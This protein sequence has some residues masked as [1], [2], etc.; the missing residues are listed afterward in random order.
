MSFIPDR[1]E[2]EE[3]E[4]E[5]TG[6]DG[7]PDA[8]ADAPD[9]QGEGMSDAV[10]TNEESETRNSADENGEDISRTDGSEET[11]SEDTTAD[12]VT[13]GNFGVLPSRDEQSTSGSDDNSSSNSSS[14]DSDDTD[15]SPTTPTD[16]RADSVADGNF[17][18]LDD[19]SDLDSSPDSSSSG[20]SE[21]TAPETGPGGIPQGDVVNTPTAERSS[22]DESSQQS[23]QKSNQPR[24]STRENNDTDSGSQDSVPD[25]GI[26]TA[27]E[28]ENPTEADIPFSDEVSDPA[29]NDDVNYVRTGDGRIVSDDRYAELEEA[30][31]RLNRP[32]APETGPSGIPQ[33]NEVGTPTADDERTEYGPED[34][35]FTTKEELEK[36]GADVSA[37]EGG[38]DTRVVT[39]STYFEEKELAKRVE[40]ETGFDTN[41]Q[42]VIQSDDGPVLSPGAEDEFELYKEDQ[43]E[44]QLAGNLDDDYPGVDVSG[45]DVVGFEQTNDGVRPELDFETQRQLVAA[46]AGVDPSEVQ[47]T[48]DGFELT[49]PSR[50]EQSNRE[51]KLDFVQWKLNKGEDVEGVETTTETEEI[52]VPIT[53][54]T[55][56]REEQEA[57]VNLDQVSVPD[58][59]QQSWMDEGE[60]NLSLDSEDVGEDLSTTEPAVQG[61]ETV[62]PTESQYQAINPGAGGLQVDIDPGRLEALDAFTT[63]GLIAENDYSRDD[64]PLP[65]LVTDATGVTEK[66]ITQASQAFSENVAEPAG[67]YLGG[68]VDTVT[69]PVT[70]EKGET[71]AGS[72]VESGTQTAIN[73]ANAPAWVNSAETIVEVGEEATVQGTKTIDPTDQADFDSTEVVGAGAEVT[74]SARQQLTKQIKEDPAGLAGSVTAGVA[75][76]YLSG[77]AASR[78][79][80][81]LRGRLATKNIDAQGEIDI[82]EIERPDVRSGESRLTRFSEQAV[83]GGKNS[84]DPDDFPVQAANDPE[85]ELR[86]L[87]EEYA[88]KD[89]EDALDTGPDEVTLFSARSGMKGDSFEPR[90]GRPYDPDAAFFAGSVSRNFLDVTGV[91]SASGLSRPRLPR[92]IKGAKSLFQA[93][94]N[95]PTIVATAGELDTLPD[96]VRTRGE[97]TEFLQENR[98]TD[99]FFVR[100][101]GNQS[102][103]AEAIVSARGADKKDPWQG[104]GQVESGETTE[105]VEY[106]DPFITEVEGERVPI[107]LF[108]QRSDGDSGTSG[109]EIDIADVDAETVTE[110]E[111]VDIATSEY[112][113]GNDGEPVSPPSGGPVATEDTSVTESGT[114][115]KAP[116]IGETI[117]SSPNQDVD[118]TAV[119]PVDETILSDPSGGVQDS[120]APFIGDEM[121]TEP[122]E[123]PSSSPLSS[124]PASAPPSSPSPE[125]VESPIAEPIEEPSVVPPT[126]PPASIPPE[127]PVTG[128]PTSTPVSMP[129]EDPF[130]PP[131]GSP[132]GSPPVGPGD[133][134]PPRR[135]RFDF[136]D[137]DDDDSIFEDAFT[138]E[139]VREVEVK[140]DPVD[141]VDDIFD[142]NGGEDVVADFDNIGSDI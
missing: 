85:T 15:A 69:R 2:I 119:K 11:I 45:N 41:S 58:Y 67:E 102:G 22:E 12:D 76:G 77:V 124:T 93:A 50:E 121:E 137:D 27:S 118:A 48:P 87:A 34:L 128:P 127:E 43:I 9:D 80:T 62:A 71:D 21:V 81:G 63:G 1:D 131:T 116:E 96:N 89:L 68:A 125:P 14:T 16:T 75:G 57:D 101:G 90:S 49:P 8:T 78:A 140:F 126:S 103:E 47:Y 107:Q 55:V 10:G 86:R 91:P 135:P 110:T 117:Q 42:D 19:D 70:G 35:T 100:Q 59:F 23:D 17:G 28:V 72:F 134:T 79:F 73:F 13:D 74:D 94:R 25:D 120:G 112:T 132:T 30:S 106:D 40:E 108:R 114:E 66:D 36:Q 4:E 133:S 65:A 53:G 115:A 38:E 60:N 20:P 136:G 54:D 98:N 88:T 46:N 129:P 123:S 92:P 122:V 61:K 18:I 39:T 24:R 64:G 104:A 7:V 111:L 142:D 5:A 113:P 139:G 84:M 3:L 31:E 51:R 32:D 83:P 109:S 130:G 52:T 44:A 29:S 56:T 99:T 26:P 105:F 82:G 95:Q 138:A 141:D 33:G 6:E 37:I 97:I